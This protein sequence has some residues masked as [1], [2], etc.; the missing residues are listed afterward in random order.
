MENNNYK[1]KYLPSFISQLNSTLNYIIKILNNKNAAKRLYES[2]VEQIE[3]RSKSQ[4]GYEKYISK[5]NVIYYR[6][7]VKNYTIF[8]TLKND[9][10]EARRFLYSKRNF[11]K[12][13]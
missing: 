2:V 4:K 6:I 3:Q 13:L 12:I 11:K 1:I 7:Y 5:G 10:M 8:Y 9:V